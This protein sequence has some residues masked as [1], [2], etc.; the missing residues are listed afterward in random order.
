MSN[1]NWTYQQEYGYRWRAKAISWLEHKKIKITTD[2][3]FVLSYCHKQV[4]SFLGRI[5][6]HFIQRLKIIKEPFIYDKD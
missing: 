5:T 4:R 3:S 2:S 6:Q 1:Y